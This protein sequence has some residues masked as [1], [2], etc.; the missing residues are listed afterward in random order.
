MEPSKK[1][2]VTGAIKKKNQQQK[3]HWEHESLAVKTTKK[4]KGIKMGGG[5]KGMSPRVF[6]R[7]GGIYENT[8]Q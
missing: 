8:E 5:V 2:V 3:N 4:K 7:A 6:G 1:P